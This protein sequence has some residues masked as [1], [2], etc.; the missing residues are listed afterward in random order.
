[1]TAAVALG[2]NLPGDFGS[3]E[4]AIRVAI[5][6][7]RELGRVVA[8][9]ELL[10]TAPVGYAQQP[11]F[12]NGALVLETNLSPLPLLRSLLEIERS[13]GRVRDGVVA[14]GPRIIDLDLIW[15]DGLVV[16]SDELILPHPALA[17]RAFVLE[18]LAKIAAD[19]IHPLLGLSVIE[20]LEQMS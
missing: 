10:D 1:M 6:R 20:M 19:W 16:V 18:P 7:I 4:G 14:K 5:N 13:M 11:R 12:L 3:R 9:S 8:V 15:V 2:S 17:E